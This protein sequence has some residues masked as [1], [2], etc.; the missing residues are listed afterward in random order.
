[1]LHTDTC[2]SAQCAKGFFS[3]SQLSVQIL[4]HCS[5]THCAQSHA[6]TSARMSK[7]LNTAAARAGIPLLGH[8]KILHTLVAV[9]SVA[10]AAA[11]PYQ[12]MGTW[13]SCKGQRSTKQK[14]MKYVN[15][16]AQT[17]SPL[18]PWWGHL[19]ACLAPQLSEPCPPSACRTAETHTHRDTH[20]QTHTGTHKVMHI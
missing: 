15:S 8:T 6:S 13:I 10:L 16:E 14:K 7:I 9:G 5:Y 17:H 2:L 19:G 20:T 11:V 4:S 18:P 12:G 3:Q 1:M